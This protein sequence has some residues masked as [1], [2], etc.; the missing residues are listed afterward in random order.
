[1]KRLCIIPIL[2]LAANLTVFSQT[3]RIAVQNEPLNKVLNMLEMEISF[4]DRALSEYRVSV[5]KSFENPEKALLYL[6]ENKPFRIEKK[7]KV[8]VIVAL[9]N[10]QQ[11]DM[12]DVE[13]ERFIFKGT[14]VSQTTGNPLEYA[15]VSLLD[16]NNQSIISGAT[17]DKGLFTIQTLRSP[18][19]IKIS[20]LGYE[21]MTK[22]IEYL[23]RELG[24][25]LLNEKMIT[26]SEVVVS[27]DK[28][29]P[30]INR[31][32]YNITPQM[33]ESVDNALELINKIPGAN[34]DKSTNTVRLNNHVNILLLVDGIQY[35]QAYLNNLSPDR[36]QAIDLVYT[37]SG[38]FLSDDYAGIIQF[39]LKK[40]YTGY[41]IHV[42]SA[43]SFNLSKKT[44]ALWTENYPNVGITYATRKLNF[45]GT[46]S[47]EWEK[48]N[49]FTTKSLT[50]MVTELVS[51]PAE[52]PNHLYRNRKHTIAGGLNYH[53]TP[54][55]LSG[56]HVDFTSGDKN[57]FQEYTMQQTDLDSMLLGIQTNSIHT[58]STKNSEKAHMFIG[59]LFYQGQFSNRLRLYGDFSYNYYYNDM[60]NEFRFQSSDFLD[61]WNEYK[62]QTVFNVEGKYILSGNRSLESGYS[63]SWR[64]YAMGTGNGIGFL[65]Y[66]ELRNNVF[67]YFTA[68][69]S[70][71]IGLKSGVA[72]EHIKQRN[73]KKVR[74]SVR[75]LPYLWLNYS[76]NPKVNIT[77]GYAVNQVYPVLYQ[78][79]PT[80]I[81]IEMYVTQNGNPDLKPA[82]RHHVFTDFS[83][84]NKLK[85][86][87]QF[88]FIKDG[89]SELYDQ[90]HSHINRTFENINFREY[91]LHVS[92]EQK[93]GANFRLNNT[94]ILF[95]NEALHAGI[96]NSLNGWIL[97]SEV[98]YYHS[99][100][101]AGVQLGYYRNMIKNLLWQGY[102]MSD[103]D[104]WCV[105]AQKKLWQNR[106]S[107]TLSYI[108]PIAFGVRYDRVKEIN[109]PLYKEKSVTNL[110][111][112]N[113]M[114]LL[115]VSLRFGRGN[116][117]PTE[118]KIDRRMDEREQ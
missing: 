62:H 66:G 5:A 49:L 88:I 55:H 23:N 64:Q 102:Q 59:T 32:T 81:R 118:S 104:Y 40:D 107:I 52:Y 35:S 48:R 19:K 22:D 117:K 47:P 51:I 4:D 75:V 15:T 45:F 36:I 73:D 98:D 57:T 111:T 89:I 16:A 8:Y 25:F 103:K 60:E 41:E 108:P 115:K 13:K 37:L 56:I 6:L 79:S 14:V 9:E 76:M 106:A 114:L 80:S 1:M 92:F 26:L 69:L 7:G 61:Y 86:M 90:N 18:A 87:P 70:D 65:D 33:R 58:N 12:K 105:T 101:A 113:R 39:I 11:E 71:K 20:Y 93:M 34:F 83:L 96:K 54:L 116:T 38:R 109:S 27:T 68:S 67:T 46:Y 99:G 84:N 85:I 95:H 31:A 74:Q 72:L 21:T 44:D 50:N 30:E 29:R 53:I 24:I 110:E 17:N 42:S 10:Q 3:F 28:P 82:V 91:N 78:F 97:Q 77:S 63:N 43:H 94:A 2:F 112:Y 100:A